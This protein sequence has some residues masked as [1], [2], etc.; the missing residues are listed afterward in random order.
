MMYIHLFVYKESGEV[1]AGRK[2]G[3]HIA[4]SVIIKS[5]MEIGFGFGFGCSRLHPR[6]GFILDNK[7]GIAKIS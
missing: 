7:F 6:Q 4:F 5:S 2:V 3:V 1:S